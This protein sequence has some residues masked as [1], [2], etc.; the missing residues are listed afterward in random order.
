MPTWF[1]GLWLIVLITAIVS[2]SMIANIAL[3]F[4]CVLG[5]TEALSMDQLDVVRWGIAAIFVLGIGLAAIQLVTK[6][7]KI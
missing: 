2:R 3:M 7:D 5:Y 6:V 4:C 1:I